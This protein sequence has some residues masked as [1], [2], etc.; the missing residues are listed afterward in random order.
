MTRSTRTVFAF[1]LLAMLYALPVA[2]QTQQQGPWF[3][4]VDGGGAHQSEADLD[5]SSGAF[6]KDRWFV[7]AGV[8]YAFDRRNSIGMSVGGGQS[9]YEFTDETNFGGGIPWG[10]IDDTRLSLNGRFG[11][12]ET[13]TVFVIPTLRFNGEKDASSSD[14]R[15][16]GVFAAATWRVNENLTIGPGVGIFSRL[17]SSTKFF[18]ILAIDWNINDRWNL[19]TGRGLAASQ[20]PG[21]TLSYELNEDWSFGLTGRYENLEF[22]L[23]DEGPAAGGVGKDKSIPMVFSA[24]LTPNEKLEFSVFAGIE[25]AGE[26]K[27]KDAMD[28][29]V[30]KSDY[31]AAALFGATFN[32]RF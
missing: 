19:S 12:G 4:T 9:D 17:E 30:E 18:P 28:E 13:G 21:L 8:D 25:F 22:R 32:I 3:F 27:L 1:T 16:W 20:G 29:L 15:T 31:D 26:L 11:F 10:K 6:S 5:D 2:A 14:S 24:N 7:S 23:D